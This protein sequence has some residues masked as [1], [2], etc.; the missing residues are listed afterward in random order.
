MRTMDRIES[1]RKTMPQITLAELLASRHQ[2]H[3]Y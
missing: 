3:K 2:G 1:F